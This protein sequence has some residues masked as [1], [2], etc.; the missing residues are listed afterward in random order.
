MFTLKSLGKRGEKQNTPTARHTHTQ[1]RHSFLTA[2]EEEEESH[3][4]ES[5]QQQRASV[6]SSLCYCFVSI[7]T[8][9]LELA[10]DFF[11]FSFSYFLFII[12]LKYLSLRPDHSPLPILRE[13][14]SM[15][16]QATC[17]FSSFF[18]CLLKFPCRTSTGRSVGQ[19]VDELI[20]L[21]AYHKE[22]EER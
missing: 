7:A 9:Q 16:M 13:S 22:E 10:T 17:P 20:N 8:N 15:T 18:F 11:L 3:A 1:V 6:P 14:V 12:R 4:R 2:R 5:I 19:G 21:V